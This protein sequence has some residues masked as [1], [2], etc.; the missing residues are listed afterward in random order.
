MPPA[1]DAEHA[2]ISLHRDAFRRWRRLASLFFP[3]GAACS[4]PF[5]AGQVVGI[6]LGPDLDPHPAVRRD[7]IACEVRGKR[8]A[9][10]SRGHQALTN[11]VKIALA[12]MRRACPYRGENPGPG[13]DVHGELDPTPGMREQPR[14]GA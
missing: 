2:E 4:R 3:R 9:R 11:I 13:K 8:R 10:H 5:V 12:I 6:A 14:R 1:G 7:P